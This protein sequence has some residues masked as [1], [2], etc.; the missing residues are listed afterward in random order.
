MLLG[1]DREQEQLQDAVRSYLASAEVGGPVDW[2]RLVRELDIAGLAVPEEL[3]GSGAGLVEA[4]VVLGQ[5]GRVL[6]PAP[7]LSTVLALDALVSLRVDRDAPL[8]DDLV[9]R[10]VTGEHR[11]TVDGR[12]SGTGVA[13]H[14]LD[15]DEVDTFVVLAPDRDGHLAAFLVDARSTGVTRTPLD[16][17][18]GTRRLTRVEWSGVSMTP[19]TGPAAPVLDRLLA[20]AAVCLAAEQLGG[21]ER[22]LE[23]AVEHARSRSQFGRPIG[24]FQAVKHRCADVQTAIEAARWAALHAAW[25]VQERHPEATVLASMAK[26]SVSD[27]YVQAAGSAIQVLGGI[28]FTWEHPIHRFYRRAVSSRELCG[29]PDCHRERIAR[30][31][32]GE[33]AVAWTG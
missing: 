24:S 30:D 33:E 28:G 15:G 21:A 22:C 31:L 26:A 11:A 32:L 1:L 14:V 20:T 27:A 6:S 12:V 7:Y 3:G 16:G 9:A 10:V 19:L 23:L 2:Q 18:D 5:L 25:A 13:G 8:V 4:C 17:L 29:A